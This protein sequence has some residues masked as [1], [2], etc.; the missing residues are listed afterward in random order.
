[1][2]AVRTHLLVRG[3]VQGVWFRGA[4]AEEARRL[5]VGG[6]VRN[7]ADGG[8]EAEIEGAPAAVDAIVAWA[9]RGPP[10]ARVTSVEAQPVPARGER[11]FAVVG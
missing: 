9:R 1:M 6:W 7:L 3:R 10:A 11:R 4:M 5:G 2:T 8:V